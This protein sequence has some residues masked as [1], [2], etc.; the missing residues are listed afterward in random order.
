MKY[1]NGSKDNFFLICWSG[2]RPM[3]HNEWEIVCGEEARNIR[4]TQLYDSGVPHEDIMIF[5]MDDA[6]E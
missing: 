2:S 4:V 6:I 3:L 5:Y 1:E